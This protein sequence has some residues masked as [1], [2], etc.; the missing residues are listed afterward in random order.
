MSGWS[1]TC[2][3]KFISP[4]YREKQGYASTV[5][6]AE[7][8]Y[9]G[10]AR[11]SHTFSTDQRDERPMKNGRPMKL[12]R[13]AIQGCFYYTAHLTF[14]VGPFTHLH[15][16]Q[17]FTRFCYFLSTFAPLRFAG[18]SLSGDQKAISQ[19]TF[20]SIPHEGFQI[21]RRQRSDDR[22]D[23]KCSRHYRLL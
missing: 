11:I 10:L 17:P 4:Q 3:Y 22:Q 23:K 5:W 15:V 12:V 18:H 13:P 6:L 9:N 8:C 21:R 20:N 19:F 16:P 2:I 7:N 1:P 14:E